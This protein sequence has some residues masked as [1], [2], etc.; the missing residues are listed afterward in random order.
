MKSNVKLLLI[1]AA[2]LLVLTVGL[3]VVTKL[4]S[5]EDIAEEEETTTTT[6]NESRLLYDKDPSAISEIKIKNEYGEFT[7]KK[8]SDDYWGVEEF[9]GLMQDTSVVSSALESASSFTA[10]QTVSET[11]DDLAMYG[12]DNPRANV[13][14]TFEDGSTRTI[15]VGSESPKAALTYAMLDNKAPV[16]AAETAKVGVFL[17]NKFNFLQRTVY[18][19]KTAEDENDTTDYKKV[20]TVRIERSDLDYPVVLE[21]DVRQD[22]PDIISGNSSTHILTEPVRLDL[23]P[24][25]AYDLINGVFGLTAKEVAIAGPSEEKLAECGLDK[26]SC[27]VTWHI[28]GED[29]TI[30]IGNK[31]KDEEGKENNYYVAAD[32][33]DEVFLFDKAA[34][35]WT[36]FKLESITMPLI[37]TNYIFTVKTFDITT[38]DGE[39]KFT[40]SGG[41]DDFK[42]YCDTTGADVDPDLFKSFYQYFLKAPAEEIYLE[43]NSD[44]AYIT[45]KMTGEGFDETVEFID[46]GDR[47]CVIRL[48]GRTSFRTRKTYAARLEENLQRMFDGQD[49]LTTW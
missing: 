26:P 30:K 29:F 18:T 20:D 49:I 35:P 37:T 44:P 16:Y 48:N 32:G 22:D 2:V 15:T 25:G 24:D 14:I 21:Y 4:D 39:K 46:T 8:G 19:A 28:A 7:L 10:S 47:M 34:L 27:T 31:A 1:A 40:L 11:A 45:V 5:G 42:A 41:Q 23:D 43:E 17:N 6:A 36:S 12:L 33:F 13:D 38:P 3:I 9:A